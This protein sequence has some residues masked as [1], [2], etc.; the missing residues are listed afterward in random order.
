MLCCIRVY[1]SIACLVSTLLALPLK[2]RGDQGESQIK[3]DERVL[4]FPTAGHWDSSRQGWNIPIHGWIFEPEKDSISRRFAKR[5]LRSILGLDPRQPATALFERRIHW[6]LVDN[7][8]GK[9]ITIRIAGRHFTLER[10]HVD[11]HCQGTVLLQANQVREHAAGGRL[12]FSAVTRAEDTRHFSG[13]VHLCEPTGISVISD[14][15]DTIKVSEAGDRQRLLQRTFLEPFQ[16]VEG[17]AETYQQ[18]AAAGARFH[19]VSACPWQFHQPLLA[20]LKQ[21][22]FPDG[23]F[24]QKRFRIMDVS[25]SR[26]FEAPVRYKRSV[27]EALF[28]AFPRRKFFLIGDSGQKDPEVYGIIARRYPGQV[29]K[30]MI[31]DVTGQP[32]GDSRY[33]TAFQEIAAEKWLLFRDARQLDVAMPEQ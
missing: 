7:E 12:H 19:Y 4:F 25:M 30:I 5:K 23:S 17:M 22:Q 15:D 10:S 13:V 9:A 3:P 8:R 33:Q 20:F 21:K 29:E 18:F 14:I 1:L 28:T 24:H 27:I 16:A 2:L 26:L 6:F 32:R 11:G 31:R